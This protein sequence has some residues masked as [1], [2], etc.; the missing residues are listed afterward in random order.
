MKIVSLEFKSPFEDY[1]NN[2]KLNSLDKVNVV[3]GKNNSG[4]T[5]IF[6]SIYSILNRKFENNWQI[7][8]YTLELTAKE[9][10]N[11]LDDFYEKTYGENAPKENPYSNPINALVGVSFSHLIKR[12][13]DTLSHNKLLN[14][15]IYWLNFNR[16]QKS[17]ILLFALIIK[18]KENLSSLN[19]NN[20]LTEFFKNIEFFNNNIRPLN[21]LKILLLNITLPIDKI[22]YIGSIRKLESSVKEFDRNDVVHSQDIL[23]VILN[24]SFDLL[25]SGSGKPHDPEVFVIPNFSLILN[26]INEGKYELLD[27]SF[28]QK[29]FTSL[30]RIF[31]NIQLS[32]EYDE[33]RSIINYEEDG[34]IRDNLKKLGSGSQQLISLLFLFLIPGNFIY[35]IDEPENGLHPGLQIKLLQ[36][37]KNEVLT[38]KN[39]SKQFFFATHSTS[40]IDYKGNCS[41]Y[42]CKKDDTNFSIDLLE[43]ENFN[44]IREELGFTPS[45]LLQANG[46]IWVEGP[47]ELFYVK[48]LFKCFDFDL[49][50]ERILI[51]PYFG[52]GNITK[53]HL[54]LERIKKINP[55]FL[56]IMDSDKNSKNDQP[57]Q[58]R[59]NIKEK[60]EKAGYK[61]WLIEEY[62]DIEGF[63]P[64]MILN[65]FFEINTNVDEEYKKNP[66]EKL[67]NY[68]LRLREKKY[69]REDSPTYEKNRDAPKIKS[70]ILS[71]P[72]YI[73][74]IKNNLYLKTCIKELL[75]EVNKWITPSLN[76]YDI[77]KKVEGTRENLE[78]RLRDLIFQY[79]YSNHSDLEITEEI[80]Q[81]IE[82]L[83]EAAIEIL[84]TWYKQDYEQ[85]RPAVEEILYIID[86]IGL[87]NIYNEFET[88]IITADYMISKLGKIRPDDKILDPCVGNGVFVRRLLNAGV[89]KDQIKTFDIDPKYKKVIEN[90]GVSFQVKDTLLD[91][92]TQSHNEF[93]FIFLNPPLFYDYSAYMQKN[94][95]EFL[96]IY[97][98][99]IYHGTHSLFIANCIWRL[100]E[101]GK[102]AILTKDDILTKGIYEN[103][104]SIIL[105]NCIINEILLAPKDL[106]KDQDRDISPVI[107]ILTRCSGKNNKLMR[108]RNILKYISKC[109]N[110]E[111]YYNPKK[112]EKLSQHYFQLMPKKVF[113]NKLKLGLLLENNKNSN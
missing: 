34:R 12:V 90:L 19:K 98:E 77:E 75:K 55:N 99:M 8:R 71:N 33:F 23:N 37:V 27:R 45:A 30:N 66:Y 14:E 93:D 18:N 50:N 47:S 31:P 11:Y 79:F 82:R 22:K 53:E 52:V 58:R 87:E 96:N 91:F 40:F 61:F 92:N 10:K 105:E 73:E 103:L 26:R 70:K 56:I 21:D 83:G 46:I 68:I 38:D 104:R 111:E 15:S 85:V 60:F 80:I 100:K 44:I 17:N 62:Y 48:L 16:E 109:E 28:I 108:D 32:S 106:F 64:Q 102:L 13:I 86:P 51:V 54:S 9:L 89:N 29:F 74:E 88:P 36:F 101:R 107:M 112:M 113:L 41:H 39:Y 76:R 94:R 24:K 35:I 57:E 5:T 7:I 110:E 1:P 59:L 42:I 6:N 97:K 67:E 49:E 72:I 3:I 69:V 25:P 84:Y 43:R 63:I 81:E 2:I 78:G 95:L 65:D 4:K 20:E